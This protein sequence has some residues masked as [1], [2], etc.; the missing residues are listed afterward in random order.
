LG[1]SARIVQIRAAPGP[2]AWNLANGVG[3]TAQHLARAREALRGARIGVERSFFGNAARVDALV[4][5]QRLDAIV[6]PPPVS[7]G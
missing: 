5:E 6:S 7:H 2:A 4:E 1:H 3:K